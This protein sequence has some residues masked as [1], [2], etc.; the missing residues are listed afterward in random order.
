MGASAENVIRVNID[1]ANFHVSNQD[2]S[3]NDF[4]TA[5]GTGYPCCLQQSHTQTHGKKECYL[6]TKI[7][8]DITKTNSLNRNEINENS[9]N[10]VYMP[11]NNNPIGRTPIEEYTTFQ[12]KC[13]CNI[14]CPL[15]SPCDRSFP[16]FG[17]H[18]V[19]CHMPCLYPFVFNCCE[20]TCKNNQNFSV[21]PERNDKN[22]NK[23]FQDSNDN[24]TNEKQNK[25]HTSIPHCQHL[26]ECKFPCPLMCCQNQM[27]YI[28][29]MPVW[30]PQNCFFNHSI[31]HSPRFRPKNQ[32]N[33]KKTPNKNH[34]EYK[35]LCTYDSEESLTEISL[36]ADIDSDIENLSGNE[37]NCSPQ[38]K[39]C[40]LPHITATRAFK[41]CDINGNKQFESKQK[42]SLNINKNAVNC[43][44]LHKSKQD[45]KCKSRI[46]RLIKAESK[47]NEENNFTIN[48][49]VSNF[50]ETN[51]SEQCHDYN[52]PNLDNTLITFMSKEIVHDRQHEFPVK[53]LNN[54][55]WK[56][57]EN[58]V[59]LTVCQSEMDHEN[60]SVN[61]LNIKNRNISESQI[62]EKPQI[63]NYVKYTMSEDN[64]L[65]TLDQA[66]EYMLKFDSTCNSRLMNLDDNG[67]E[68]KDININER[69]LLHAGTLSP[70]IDLNLLA[71]QLLINNV[72]S[73]EE[74]SKFTDDET[75][76]F[77]EDKHDQEKEVYY[78][79]RRSLNDIH[80]ANRTN[81]LVEIKCKILKNK[82]N[83]ITEVT[84]ICSEKSDINTNGSFNDMKKCSLLL[85]NSKVITDNLEISC[86]CCEEEKTQKHINLIRSASI[87]QN[88]FNESKQSLFPLCLSLNDFSLLDHNPLFPS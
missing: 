55:V 52:E 61:M 73:E 37:N 69:K 67:S 53:E 11:H 58:D 64:A 21:S 60:L 68:N 20:H 9:S 65:D 80:N 27:C 14:N 44:E 71:R 43:N 70:E 41:N 42:Y 40:S 30:M 19:C 10:G 62:T 15:H 35:N 79:C 32:T 28:P 75:S 45:I 7:D 1:M 31:F 8:C 18:L 24:A 38:K 51:D 5:Y 82:S 16:T 3:D 13:T 17:S 47:K 22:E 29:L 81:K 49:A 76:K 39:S 25:A 34:S 57:P 72:S 36:H 88:E 48:I 77:T 59:K 78:K 87:T 85:K 54:G 50:E 26:T 56:S 46:P 33:V 2:T 66:S 83:N 12:D 63:M 84:G 23:Q 6:H 4:F 74:T 86:T